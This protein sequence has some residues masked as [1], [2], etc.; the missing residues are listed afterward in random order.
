MIKD[1]F[2]KI[3]NLNQVV[4]IGWCPNIFEI[5]NINSKL[6]IK[7]LIVTSQSQEKYFDLINLNFYT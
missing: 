1:N 6:K 5:I 3:A 7:T 4:I 2:F